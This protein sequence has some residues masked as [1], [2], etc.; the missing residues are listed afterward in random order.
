[1]TEPPDGGRNDVDDK[2][3]D[4][5][6]TRTGVAVDKPADK[7]MSAMTDVEEP[8]T[9]KD[10]RLYVRRFLQFCKAAESPRGDIRV[11]HVPEIPQSITVSNQN[12][13][14]DLTTLIESLCENVFP[15]LSYF[16]AHIYA[17]NDPEEELKLN[18]DEL[19]RKTEEL[20]KQE[21]QL[22]L[23][24]D[25]LFRKTVQLQDQVIALQ[26]EQLNRVAETVQSNFRSFSAVVTQNCRTALAPKR[27][28]KAV[29]KAA[30]KGPE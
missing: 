17:E 2:L 11:S 18:A 16:H 27:I 20:Q 15:V 22:K 14:R 3:R 21:A 24:R 8:F 25:E 19:L 28:Q 12:S 30:G 1:M 23:E 13:K 10:M 9:R 4:E 29:E 6:C 7:P 5:Q 26:G